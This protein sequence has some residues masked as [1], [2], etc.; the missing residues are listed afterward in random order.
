MVPHNGKYGKHDWVDDPVSWH[1][2]TAKQIGKD[3]L[4]YLPYVHTRGTLNEFLSSPNPLI[5]QEQMDSIWGW[6]R[7]ACYSEYLFKCVE[8][9]VS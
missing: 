1:N 9:K 8:E 3:L 7:V 4:S 2:I 6:P 5:S